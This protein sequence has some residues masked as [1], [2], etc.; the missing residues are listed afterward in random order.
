VES[1]THETLMRAGGRY[2]ELFTLQAAA[3]RDGAPPLDSAV[4]GDGGSASE[5]PI[6]EESL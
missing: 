2:A 4:D 6:V 3:Y 5:Q 1:G